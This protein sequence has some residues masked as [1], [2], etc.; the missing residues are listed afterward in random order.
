MTYTLCEL[1]KNPEIQKR[2]RQEILEKI[3]AANGVTYEAVQGMK[4]LYQVMSE[5]LRLYPPAP[6]LD[7]VPLED[8]TVG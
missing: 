5:T 7:R 8:Y 2:V 3:E 6:I 1:A 4:Y